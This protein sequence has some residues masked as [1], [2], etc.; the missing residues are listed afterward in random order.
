MKYEYLAGNPAMFIGM[1]SSVVVLV[2]APH[3]VEGLTSFGDVVKT[4]MPV[5]AMR[6][7]IA[8]PK[9]WTVED[10]KAG[11]LPEV[12][13]HIL[14]EGNIA[15]FIG[16]SHAR[17]NWCFR[18]LDGEWGIQ[19]ANKDWFA[20][21]ETPEEKAERLRNEWINEA[22]NAVRKTDV[23]GYESIYDALLSGA[24]LVPTKGGE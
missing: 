19:T 21:I 17:N 23:N 16:L 8:E 4:G 10:Q 13:N 22:I 6:R 15:E 20:P 5:I 11:R 24:L 7:I 9:R 1:P 12:G 18:R 14:I 3:S 2:N